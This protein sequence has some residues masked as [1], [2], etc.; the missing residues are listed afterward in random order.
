MKQNSLNLIDPLI[1]SNY[2]SMREITDE[3]YKK[4]I[5]EHQFVVIE[6][7]K[8]P[9][10]QN[11]IITQFEPE[12]FKLETTTVWSFPDRGDWATHKGDYRANWSPYIPRNLILRYTDESDL[13]LDQMVGSG[14]TL[15]ECKLLNRRGIGV[16]I[17]L[18]A[19]MITRNRLDFNYKYNPAIKT[20]VGDARNLDLIETESVDLIATHPPYASIIK[21]T[22]NR[23]KGDLSCVRNIDDFIQEM[24]KVAKESYRVLK[25]GK[26]CCI[27]IGDTR[28]RKHFVPITARV[29]EVFLR[30]GFILR[31]DIIKLQWKMKSTREKWRSS[32]YD[33]LLLAH[34]H[35]YVFRKPEKNERLT[36]YKN[37]KI[38]KL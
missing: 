15:I 17:N 18:D 24:H 30:I 2:E 32:K 26:H 13:V 19:I 21:F 1:N 10:I 22:N 25:P 27:L 11:H 31:E 5:S 34:E 7:T 6:N 23:I 14:T 8:V 16:D 20:Y 3:E 36:P 12:N 37:S 9:L 38:W 29:L 35:L 28:K 33:F 4:F